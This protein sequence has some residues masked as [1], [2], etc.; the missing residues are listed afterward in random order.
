MRIV[1]IL[2]CVLF[3]SVGWA[4]P[5]SYLL[6]RSGSQVVFTWFLG[7]DAIKGQMPVKRA[8]LKLDFKSAGNSSIDVALDVSK[9]KAG[10][11]FATGAMRGPKVLSADAH[12]EIRFKSTKV[13]AQGTGAK[14]QGDLTIRGVTRPAIFD[15]KLYRGQGSTDSS[16][17]AVQM[18]GSVNRSEFGATGWPDLVSDEIEINI[19]AQV[20]RQE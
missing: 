2:M 20:A 17:L 12:P 4:A 5:N 3:A 8:D 19:L 15:V 1:V 18:T 16:R 10:F 14:V 9:A 13:V 11:A 7:A 6:D